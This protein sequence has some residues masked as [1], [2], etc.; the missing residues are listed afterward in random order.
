MSMQHQQ[1]FAGRPLDADKQA[2]FEAAAR[3]ST[4]RQHAIERADDI[5]F[6]KFMQ[7]YFQQS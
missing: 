3:E 7:N 5:P 2:M 1:W 6:D 4:E